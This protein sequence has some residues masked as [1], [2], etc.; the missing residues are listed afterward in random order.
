MSKFKL[1]V[2]GLLVCTNAFALYVPSWMCG[3]WICP[4]CDT[5]PAGN[6]CY[7]SIAPGP[8]GGTGVTY[9]PSSTQQT[10]INKCGR[11]LSCVGKALSTVK[12][13]SVNLSKATYTKLTSSSTK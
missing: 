9:S 8:T 5:V 13:S 10:S 3:T 11:D 2:L 1:L 7:A 4:Y 12:K 6:I